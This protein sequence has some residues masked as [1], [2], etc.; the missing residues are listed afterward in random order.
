MNANLLYLFI[1][2]VTDNNNVYRG[3]LLFLDGNP[4][5]YEVEEY[6][7]TKVEVNSWIIS[8]LNK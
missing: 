4:K 8:T 7:T 3:G 6:I 1:K 5:G 2:V